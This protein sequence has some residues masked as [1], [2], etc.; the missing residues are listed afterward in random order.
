MS[1]YN[2]NP[3]G[4]QA[5]ARHRRSDRHRQAESAQQP[6]RGQEEEIQ[7]SRRAPDG[8][9][10]PDPET[11]RPSV[12]L[13]EDDREDFED[14]EEA[15]YGSSRF[16]WAKVICIA[17]AALVL[18]CGA[19]LLLKD[20]G[21]LTPLKNAVSGL[22]NVQAKAPAEA[23]S[24]QAASTEA[25]TNSRV[26]FNLT[27]NQSVD[28][29]KLVDVDDNEI[30]ATATL[31]NGENETNRIWSIQAVFDEPYTGNVYAMI[32]SGDTWMRTDKS[33]ALAV[34]RPTPAPTETPPPTQVPVVTA[35]PATAAPPTEIPAAAGRAAGYG[36][37][38]RGPH[39]GAHQS[40]RSRGGGDTCAYCS[41]YPGADGGA[42]ASAY[43]A[44]HHG[45]HR[46]A[47]AQAGGPKRRP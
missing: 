10:A 26:V 34:T 12:R 33:V 31:A 42:Y 16:P 24:F 15:D 5:P 28:G 36:G 44:A 13:N 22:L 45:A 40:S 23:L 9:F 20:A 35:A 21:P 2:K 14:E 43:R 37:R 39:L 17:A 25:L 47:P 46:V 38:H 3:E 18:L 11:D 1:D 30:T 29:V 27:T 8:N 4:W 19:S 32:R 41:A 6:V 7:W